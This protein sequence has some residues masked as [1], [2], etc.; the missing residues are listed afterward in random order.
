MSLVLLAYLFFRGVAKAVL[1]FIGIAKP[2][3]IGYWT[4]RR[5]KRTLEDFVTRL[6]GQCPVQV[7]RGSL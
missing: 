7:Y 6:P 3:T 4:F 1:L 5:E 2:E